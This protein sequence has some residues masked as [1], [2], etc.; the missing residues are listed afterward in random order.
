MH[1]IT[2]VSDCLGITEIRG[3]LVFDIATGV[4]LWIWTY[5]I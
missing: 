3:A 5:R 1:K 2:E 4:F